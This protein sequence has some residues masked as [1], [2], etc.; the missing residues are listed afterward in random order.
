MTQDSEDAS[1]FSCR[2]RK[3]HSYDFIRG[4]RTPTTKP[5]TLSLFRISE[6]PSLRGVH[7]LPS[8]R[9]LESSKGC[10]NPGFLKKVS[11]LSS[12]F[13]IETKYRISWTATSTH[14]N[15]FPRGIGREGSKIISLLSHSS[16]DSC[17]A[18]KKS[19]SDCFLARR[20]PQHL[21]LVQQSRLEREP[22]V[23]V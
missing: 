6:S 18:L 5:D 4:P 14:R 2:P 8:L 9:T 16:Y 10:G 20:Q 12:I 7:I 15:E 23:I 21:R 13:F 11:N 17:V 3:N 19:N 22:L 1:T